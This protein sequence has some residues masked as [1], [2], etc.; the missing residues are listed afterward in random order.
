MSPVLSGRPD[1]IL[2]E[3][4]AGLLPDGLV[5]VPVR[6]GD[7]E[8]VTELMRAA[9]L[10]ACGSST[11]NLAEV[12]NDL[13]GADC[14]WQRGAAM[15]R[16]FVLPGARSNSTVA[17][18]ASTLPLSGAFR[19]RMTARVGAF[20]LDTAGQATAPARRPAPAPVVRR[21]TAR[22]MQSALGTAFAQDEEF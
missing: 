7:V 16:R 17:V 6:P 5:A 12:R 22:Q 18:R 14:G 21:G 4:V 15:V 3:A 13:A 10:A 9:E 2:A 1:R 11:T 8:S 19:L 20:R